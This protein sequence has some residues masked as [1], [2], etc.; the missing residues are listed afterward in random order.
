MSIK[1]EFV[2]NENTRGDFPYLFFLSCFSV[3]VVVTDAYCFLYRS[4]ST[5]DCSFTT[6]NCAVSTRER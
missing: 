5:N 1:T 4:Q 2:H 3:F 6:E